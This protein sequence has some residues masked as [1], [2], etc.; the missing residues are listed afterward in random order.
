MFIAVLQWS[1]L[2]RVIYI[3][4]NNLDMATAFAG[5]FTFIIVWLVHGWLYRWPRTRTT[6]E[7][8]EQGIERVTIPPHD[9]V[10]RLFGKRPG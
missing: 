4:N 1:G 5:V 3:A 6:D 9:F 10:M 7:A 2:G 8:I